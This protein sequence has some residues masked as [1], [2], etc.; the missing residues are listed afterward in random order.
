IMYITS[1][2]K[3]T[4]FCH[5]V[6]LVKIRGQQPR[7]VV[8]QQW[9]NTDRLLAYQVLADSS[10]RQRSR[11][12]MFE[13]LESTT[14]RLVFFIPVPVHIISRHKTVALAIFPTSGVD[15]FSSPE[16]GL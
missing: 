16:E 8:L 15:R 12:F 6:I 9:I 4:A 1:L 14:Q 7:G 11:F 2:Q 10:R 5:P 3:T 13:V